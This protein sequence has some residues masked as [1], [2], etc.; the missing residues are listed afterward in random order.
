MTNTANIKVTFETE[1]CGRCGGTGQYPSACWQGVCLGCSGRGVRLTRRGRAARNAYD[2]TM[3][4]MDR[5]Y[6]DVKIGD[7]VR[8]SISPHGSLASTTKWVIVESIKVHPKS[9]KHGDGPW[10]DTL[11]FT[12]VGIDAE[13]YNG[14]QA[15]ATCSIKIWD[16]D[17]FVA[18]ARRV[19][20]MKGAT[21]TGLD[22]T[23]EIEELLKPVVTPVVDRIAGD[24]A[25]RARRGSHAD[26][27]HEAT[28]AARRR[29]R[30]SR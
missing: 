10:L 16:A 3:S 19:D 7:R 29:C 4:A 12:Y 13:K 22:I 24:N 2:E 23:S 17:V 20:R 28:P 5:T 1:T 21:V 26:C 15:D 25:A 6:G 9:I 14:R 18:A 8:M 11:S 27:D 30:A